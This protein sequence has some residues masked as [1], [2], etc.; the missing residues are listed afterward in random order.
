L[1]IFVNDE[2]G[3]IPFDGTERVSIK[4]LLNLEIFKIFS[5]NLKL[6]Q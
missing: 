3:E 1:P 2:F 5:Q 4:P 6:T